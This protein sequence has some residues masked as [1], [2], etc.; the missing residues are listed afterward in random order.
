MGT[1]KLTEGA[2]D[3]VTIA[4]RCPVELKYKLLVKFGKNLD[5]DLTAT[6]IRAIESV[7]KDVQL[8]KEAVD[9]ILDDEAAAY[10]KRM[11]A[12]L[13]RDQKSGRV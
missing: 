10:K 5:D 12:R 8:T 7:T 11:R 1:N 13:L 3:K 4:F 2:L 6:M 9:R